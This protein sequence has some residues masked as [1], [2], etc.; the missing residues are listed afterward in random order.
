[1]AA[2]SQDQQL[3]FWIAAFEIQDPACHRLIPS[4]LR[5]KKKT[6]ILF[7]QSRMVTHHGNKIFV[8]AFGR[9]EAS[10]NHRPF[11]CRQSFST[12]NLSCQFGR[13]VQR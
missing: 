9:Y 12:G 13:G 8:P 4:V 11:L 2:A 6:L 3:N 1:V 7:V 10:W 5:G